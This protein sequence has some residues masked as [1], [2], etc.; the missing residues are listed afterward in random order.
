MAAH[1]EGKYS[2]AAQQFT[3]AIRLNPRSCV[4]HSNRAAAFLK[5]G[6]ADLGLEDAR[7][8]LLFPYVFDEGLSVRNALVVHLCCGDPA[9]K[10][11]RCFDSMLCP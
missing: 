1:R 9:L 3:E 6:R 7:C 10:N 5:L 4:Y 8:A 2:V 11:A